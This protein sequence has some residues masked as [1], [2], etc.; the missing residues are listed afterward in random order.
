MHNS[1]IDKKI[2]DESQT[3]KFIASVEEHNIFGGLE[4]ISEYNSTL[5][6]SPKQLFLSQR[7]LWC[8]TYDYLK[9]NID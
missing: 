8:G 9:E 7:C 4:A 1:A 6:N 3:F 2:L 5:K